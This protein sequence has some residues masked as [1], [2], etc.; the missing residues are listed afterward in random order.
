MIYIERK[1]IQGKL[2]YDRF[3]D[4][5]KRTDEKKIEILLEN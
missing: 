5:G 2:S 3:W 4:I 1:Q